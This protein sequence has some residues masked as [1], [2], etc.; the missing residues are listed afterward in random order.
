MNKKIS[1]N[2]ILLFLLSGCAHLETKKETSQAEKKVNIQSLN[3]KIEKLNHKDKRA[4]YQSIKKEVQNYHKL[5][6]KEYR[7]KHYYNALKAYKRVNFYEGR[8]V[9]T[10]K[11]LHYIE[12]KAQD[13]AIYHYKKAKLYLTKDKKRALEELNIVMMNKPQYK[14]TRE[15]YKRVKNEKMMQ[16]YLNGLKN[17]LDTQIANYQGSYNE[18]NAIHKSLHQ[19]AKY[20]YQNSSVNKAQNFLESQKSTLK[21]KAISLYKE[22]KLTT[23]KEKFKEILTLYPHDIESV[24][25]FNK[26]KFKQSKQKNLILAKKMLKKKRYKK[27]IT[28]ATKVLRLESSNTQAQQIIDDANKKI[29]QEIKKGLSD[30]IRYYNTK[31]LT[32]AKECF[33]KVLKIDSTN[34]A[35]LIYHKKI[36]RQLHT[37]KSLQ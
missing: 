5:G 28:Y 31:H 14:D 13:R 26:I 33:E 24:K 17:Q 4:I 36:Q 37:I 34:S 8:N 20:D 29:E 6:D 1:I 15:L 23:A 11:K 21:E 16:I 2:L 7:D 30:G 18:L 12:K 9:I 25:Y 10:A 27:A 22:H 19:L 32:Q 35:A 3:K